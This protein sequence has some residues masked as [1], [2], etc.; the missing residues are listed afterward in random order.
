MVNSDDRYLKPAC[1][2]RDEQQSLLSYRP[3]LR[4]TQTEC[5]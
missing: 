5:G 4:C 3:L 1:L 2:N